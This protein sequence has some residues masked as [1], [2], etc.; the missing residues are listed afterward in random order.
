M[1]L[2]FE[3][4]KVAYQTYDKMAEEGFVRAI[5]TKIRGREI[6]IYTITE[7]GKNAMRESLENIQR[8]V[9][10]DKEIRKLKKE[11]LREIVA[12]RRA[13]PFYADAIITKSGV[14]VSR[15]WR[16]ISKAWQIDFDKVIE[17]WLILSE[18][19]TELFGA[20]KID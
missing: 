20:I 9:Q 2:P 3:K 10:I 8:I 5:K 15:P 17:N 7:E 1:K 6:T 14:I 16:E 11:E 19:G 12:P 4:S 18:K 13:S